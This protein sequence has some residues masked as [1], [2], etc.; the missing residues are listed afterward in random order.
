MSPHD[1]LGIADVFPDTPGPATLY[2]LDRLEG[3]DRDRFS[4]RP[5]TIRLLAEN[6]A[7]NFER[8]NSPKKL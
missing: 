7:R 8:A 5:L 3:F 6:L 4:R 2:R 1:P